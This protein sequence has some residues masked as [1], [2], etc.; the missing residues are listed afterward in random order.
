MDENITMN[1]IEAGERARILS[2]TIAQCALSLYELADHDISLEIE[3]NDG[4]R[5]EIA[6]REIGGDVNA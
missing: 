4:R 3:T 1:I 2:N 6:L 5:I